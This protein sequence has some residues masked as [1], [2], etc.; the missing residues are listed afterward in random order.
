M[1]SNV[2]W[3]VQ[4]QLRDGVNLA[5]DVYRPASGGRRT[6]LLSRTP[7]NKNTTVHQQ[8]AAVYTD[9]G[10]NF[11]WVDAR[12][13][14]DSEGQFIPWRNEATD[15]YDCIE[16][17]ASQPWSDGNVVTWG[18]SYGAHNQLL[19][20]LLQPP[21][22]SAMIL[23]VAPSDPFEDN[24]SGVP[25]PWEVC[26]FRMLDGRVLQSVDQID[27]PKVFWHLPLLTMDEHAGFYSDHW[28]SHLSHSITESSF[29]D[30][31]RYQPRLR[32]IRVPILHITGWYDDVQRGTMTNFTRLTDA[33][34]PE[35]VARQ[36]WLVVGPWDHR[37]TNLRDSRLGSVEFGDTAR[38]DLPALERQWLGAIFGGGAAPARVRI[39]TMG[40]NAWRDEMEWP[41]ARTQWSPWFLSSGGRAN[42]KRGDGVLQTAEPSPE[43]CSSDVFEYDP[44]DP[45]PFLSAFASSSQIG[46]PDDY[47]AI[48]E[49]RDILVYTSAPV[50][51]PL[52]VTGPV[53]LVLYAASSAVDTDFVGRLIDL[54]P[55]GVAQ[56]ICDGMVRARF[57]L[58]YDVPERFLTP[59]ETV[60]YEIDMWSTSHTFLTGHKLRLEVTSSAFP[61]YDRNLNT[62]GAIATGTEMAVAVNTVYH[63]PEQASHLILPVVPVSD[64]DG[65]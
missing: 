58:G 20:A 19:T 43:D 8:R 57:R 22:L 55:D 2:L 5:A 47:A 18:A 3:N 10:Y 9:Y 27:W 24:P 29:W 12:G 38:V 32:E 40:Q 26:W 64:K 60:R 7:Y 11:V 46:G 63:S 37:C 4:I 53:R 59:G 23:Y 1:L 48:E 17:V 31:V 61:R 13:R 45:V 52:E 21:H 25:T 35:E 51:E 44:S 28:R 36:Q 14:G 54:H 41:L 65:L 56:R 49:R 15:G 16:W 42:G 50:E 39:F 6:T 30:V 34:A 33:S 62:G